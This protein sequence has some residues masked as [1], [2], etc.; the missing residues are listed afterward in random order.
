MV[1]VI[2]NP[3]PRAID[4]PVGWVMKSTVRATRNSAVQR[5]SRSGS[6]NDADQGSPIRR[7]SIEVMR[8]V[9]CMA[10]ALSLGSVSRHHLPALRNSV[11]SSAS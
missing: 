3:T 11:T 2:A 10:G 1:Q 6:H 5:A 8:D 4:G 7:R 9:G